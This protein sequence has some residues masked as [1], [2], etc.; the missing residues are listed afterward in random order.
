MLLSILSIS[1][2]IFEFNRRDLSLYQFLYLLIKK[3]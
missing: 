2:I 1:K 3:G